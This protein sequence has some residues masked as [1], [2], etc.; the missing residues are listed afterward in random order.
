TTFDESSTI[1][2]TCKRPLPEE[3]VQ[4]LIKAFEENKNK[5]LEAIN[6]EGKTRKQTLIEAQK[7][8]DE[9]KSILDLKQ[10]TVNKLEV[11]LNDLNNQANTLEKE[12]ANVNITKSPQYREIQEKIMKLNK[13]KEELE[14]LKIDQDNTKEVMELENQIAEINKQLARVDLAKENEKRIE[15]LKDRERMLANMVAQTEKIEYLCDQYV[16]TQAE[17]LEDKLNSKFKTVKF[18][19]FDIQVNG[20]INETFETTVNGVPFNDLNNAAKINA[21]LDI[22]NTLTDYYKIKAPIFIDNRESVNEII[23]VKSQVINLIVSKDK[24]LRVEVY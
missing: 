13:E 5:E 11:E 3:D 20:G 22:I 19:L 24:E 2:P 4:A 17:L 12:I 9:L 1:C 23:D 14:K 7:E 15:E 18:K 8:L 21:G 6:Q 10:E 16:I